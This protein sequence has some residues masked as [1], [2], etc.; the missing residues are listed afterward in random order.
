MRHEQRTAAAAKTESDG[1]FMTSLARGLAVMQTLAQ[2][3]RQLTV[4]LIS[5]QTGISRAAVRRCLHTLVKL[6]FAGS[7]DQQHF[8]LSPKV[9]TLGQASFAS[10][11]L[12][13]IAQPVLERLSGVL[14]E[15]C[16]VA[17]LQ[18][19]EVFYIAR[20]AVSRIMSV[21]LKVG[22]RLPAYCTSMGRVMLAN[23]R[24]E[25]L[26][27]HLARVVLKPHTDRTVVSVAKLKRILELVNRSGY[28]I[29][30]QELEIG[31]RSLA[32]PIRSS[33]GEVVAAVNVG[34]HAQ[35]VSIRD[36]QTTFLPH[37]RQAAQEIGKMM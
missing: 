30:D 19:T 21:D 33:T 24:P 3:K 26:D 7:Q 2:H 36:L 34:C 22:S 35:R 14:S 10:T 18:D 5:V 15:S 12:A 9:L 28:A 27:S 31:L 16:S 1:D 4:S 32:V 6:G 25:Q 13:K 29:V 37:L 11:S 23:L 17:T 20:A 8:F